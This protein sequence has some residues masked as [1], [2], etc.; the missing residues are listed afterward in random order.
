MDK[1]TFEIKLIDVLAFNQD[2]NIHPTDVP[3]G[4]F[5]YWTELSEMIGIDLSK[6]TEI[7]AD[8]VSKTESCEVCGLQ[9]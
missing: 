1:E 9:H 6:E 2:F 8:L 4:E 5:T 3:K 7:S